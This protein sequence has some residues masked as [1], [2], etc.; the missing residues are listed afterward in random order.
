MRAPYKLDVLRPI[1][2]EIYKYTYFVGG[3][4]R[5]AYSTEFIT[6]IYTDVKTEYKGVT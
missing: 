1:A 6:Y 5:E 2:A 4:R 3:L